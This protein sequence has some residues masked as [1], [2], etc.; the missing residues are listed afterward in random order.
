MPEQEDWGKT[1]R[2]GKETLNAIERVH[3]R[4]QVDNEQGSEEAAFAAKREQP[5]H[6]LPK[7]ADPQWQELYRAVRESVLK[8]R[9]SEEDGRQKS[10]E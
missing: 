4:E 6:G 9:W 2:D 7:Q 3:D 8:L 1:V 5:L 10:R